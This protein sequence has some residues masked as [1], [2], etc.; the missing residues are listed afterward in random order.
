MSTPKII[1]LDA[2]A[3][4]GSSCIRRLFYQVVEGYTTKLKYN[5]L[6]FGTATHLF[7]AEIRK[8]A[9]ISFLLGLQ[10][11]KTYYKN[12]PMLIKKDKSYMTEGFL[13]SVCN[14]YYIKYGEGKDDFKPIFV[15][16]EPLVELKFSIPVYTSDKLIVFLSGVIDEIGKFSNGCYAIGDLKTTSVWDVEK[17]FKGYQLS[18]QMLFYRYML[19]QHARLYPKSI[20][21]EILPQFH[22]QNLRN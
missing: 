16:K 19:E 12:K 8:G 5:D 10:R 11:A 15:D 22:H 18:P 1:H 13:M 7:K 17:Y 14:E 9:E 20:F 4:S 6:E 3:F 2:T 21:A